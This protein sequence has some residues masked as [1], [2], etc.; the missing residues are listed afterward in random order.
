MNT[1]L[2][3][4]SST[5]DCCN[6]GPF[7]LIQYVHLGWGGFSVYRKIPGFFEKPVFRFCPSPRT[8]KPKKLEK[9]R[10]PEKTR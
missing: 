7:H 9:D 10:K 2:Q 3:Y 5:E 4:C 6:I 8:E 1:V